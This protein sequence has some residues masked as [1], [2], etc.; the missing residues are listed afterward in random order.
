METTS[1]L[2][3]ND[4]YNYKEASHI[5]YDEDRYLQRNRAERVQLT[6]YTGD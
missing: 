3:L 5:K 4:K 2:A 6:I 1:P